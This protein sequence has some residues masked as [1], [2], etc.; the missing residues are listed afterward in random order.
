[1]IWNNLPAKKTIELDNVNIGTI[2]STPG[3]LEA[4]SFFARAN[5]QHDHNKTNLLR[6]M[7]QRL[8]EIIQKQTR[9]QSTN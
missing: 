9:Q 4:K 1:M 2:I 5:N 6:L 8:R 7:R 3:Y